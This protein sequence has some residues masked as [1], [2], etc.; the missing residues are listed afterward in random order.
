MGP[1]T[2]K[3]YFIVFDLSSVVSR[4]LPTETEPWNSS[5]TFFV[6]MLMTPPIASEP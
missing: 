2:L 3:L 6:M 5:V 1:A 4:M